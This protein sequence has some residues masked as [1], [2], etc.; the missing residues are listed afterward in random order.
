MFVKSLPTECTMIIWDSLLSEGRE[1][2][3]RYAL[4]LLK[5]HSDKLSRLEGKVEVFNY[6]KVN[7]PRT[8]AIEQLT[9]VGSG[10]R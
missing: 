7:V 2:L 9:H 6:M 1:V 8:T 3:F 4:A 10:R 5:L